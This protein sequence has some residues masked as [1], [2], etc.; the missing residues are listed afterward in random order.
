M[1]DEAEVE[2]PGYGGALLS[3]QL[4]PSFLVLS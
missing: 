1:N 2:P 4:Y 3:F